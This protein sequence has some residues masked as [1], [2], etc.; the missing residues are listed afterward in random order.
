MSVVFEAVVK[1]LEA[2]RDA[3]ASRAARHA[4]EIAKLKAENAE[5]HRKLHAE[6]QAK[7]DAASGQQEW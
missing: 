3:L 2:Q 7:A 4:G 6:Q 5:L 1:E